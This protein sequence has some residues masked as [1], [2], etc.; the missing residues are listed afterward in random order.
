MYEH[1]IYVVIAVVIA[2]IAIFYLLDESKSSV[3]NVENIFPSD[4]NEEKEIEAQRNH[5]TGT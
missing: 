4:V 3:S 5:V 2:L 1:K